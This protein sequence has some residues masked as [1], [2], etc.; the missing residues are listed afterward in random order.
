M[1]FKNAISA[2][3]YVFSVPVAAQLIA[4]QA[5]AEGGFSSPGLDPHNNVVAS[6]SAHG[7]VN[8][9][10]KVSVT[11]SGADFDLTSTTGGAA[12]AGHGS[13]AGT[14]GN[15]TAVATQNPNSTVSEDSKSRS[16][17]FSKGNFSIV[18]AA[19]ETRT[20][21]VVDGKTYLVDEVALA[22]A[23]STAYGSSAAVGVDAAAT[24]APSGSYGA[25][26]TSTKALSR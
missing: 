16:I 10:E 22:V 21:V 19:T 14:S 2:I 8:V 5:Y 25:Q 18:K 23:R 26:V 13:A 1:N 4:T 24:G 11:L 6:Y 20:T 15:T 9:S 12:G 3:L 7:D 17:G